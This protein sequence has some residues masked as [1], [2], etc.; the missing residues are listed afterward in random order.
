MSN[1]LKDS[2]MISP[3][4]SEDGITLYCGDCR[5]IL[6]ILPDKSVDLVLTDPPYGLGFDYLDFND[7]PDNV[8]SLLKATIGDMQR[9]S[10]R[11]AM[12]ASIS[13]LYR[14]PQAK[15]IVSC[16]W[17]TTGSYGFFGFSQWFPVLMWGE[18]V[19]AQTGKVNG[20]LKSDVI[21]VSGGGGVGFMRNGDDKHPCPKPLTLWLKLMARFSETSVCDPFVGSGTTLV[22][23][24]QLGRRAIGIEISEKY[25]QIAVD[26]L[27]QMELFTR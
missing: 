1:E 27:R 4:Y 19:R 10:Q 16:S 20:I 2:A 15:W 24:K 12:A 7:T 9:V 18:D 13:N 14:F 5:E 11:V 25:C 26:R 23:A 21:T 3:Y 8:E 6:P 22:A 17:N